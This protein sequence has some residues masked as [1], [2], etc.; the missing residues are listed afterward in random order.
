MNL[1]SGNY[2]W[3]SI[4]P[5][6]PSY[7]AL[8]QDTHCDVLIIGGGGSAAQCAFQ[9]ADKGLAVAVIEKAKI[10]SGSTSANSA[11]LQYSGEKFFTSLTHSF[12]EGYIQRHLQLLKTAIDDIERSAEV[13][14]DKC[15]FRRRDT[16]YF[17][18]SAGDVPRL[19][20]EY[21]FLKEQGF[22]LDYLEK[23]DIQKRYP[24]VKEAAIYVY[25]DAEYNPFKFAHQLLLYASKKGVSVYENT[26]MNG[27]YFD[28]SLKNTIV[29][30]KNGHNIYAKTVIFSAGYEN[31]DIRKEKQA[32]F[33]STYTMTT[34]PLNEASLKAWYNRTLIWETARPYLYLRTTADNRVIIGGLDENT[35]D[36]LDR[37][38]KLNHKM[39]K[40]KQEFQKLFP[41]IDVEPAF[42][43]TGYYGGT[44]DG[45][46]IIG[47][48]D[49]FPQCYFLLGYGDNGTVYSQLLAGLISQEILTGSSIDLQLYL[50]NRPLKGKL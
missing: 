36:P 3:P 37:D 30:T 2:Y 48:Y 50:Q 41:E 49:E 18:S 32:S 10:G 20:A 8:Q 45:L 21:S 25:N 28:K 46:P 23:R 7:P 9:L 5:E 12:G 38:S 24:F 40:L 22:P 33:V 17:A 27:H 26:E 43:L 19:K 35:T 39:K 16:L 44:K 29:R 42:G 11:L 47:K 4:F 6:A 34:K 31:M 13:S 15:E 1:Q 14:G